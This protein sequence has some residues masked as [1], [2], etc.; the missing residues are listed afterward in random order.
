[1][2][3]SKIAQMV[4]IT[5]GA[6]LFLPA[7]S[8]T[9]SGLTPI[10]LG[11]P[12]DC[13]LGKDCFVQNYVDMDPGEDA[14]DFTCGPLAYNNHQGT[15]FRLRN[16][17]ALKRPYSALA[18]APGKVVQ[19]INNRP[20]HGFEEGAYNALDCGNAV[21]INHGGG[22]LSQYCHLAEGSV[23]VQNGD[24]VEKGQPIGFIGS[25]GGTSFPHLHYA[26]R[27]YNAT[28]DPFIGVSPTGCEAEEAGMLWDES[29]D[30]FYAESAVLGF[31]AT[32]NFP[33]L[34]AMENGNLS[35][36]PNEPYAPF[37][38]WAHLMG[39]KEGD[40]L[41]FLAFA[42]EGKILASERFEITEDKTIF[43]A[44]IGVEPSDGE[45]ESWPAGTYEG[46][47]AF[48]RGGQEIGKRSTTF[49]LPATLIQPA[50]ERLDD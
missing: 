1:M 36:K 7:A 17:A 29:V 8:P 15:D 43:S 49:T 30:I 25:S 27:A 3:F 39:V 31:G 21:M 6:I 22:W 23:R 20:D 34:E 37:Y 50:S 33:N 45:F 42:P 10:K 11:L 47:F 32:R 40:T 18:T 46:R 26:I 35:E 44:N 28:I 41:R 19:V 9:P 2:V 48:Y 16:R 4:V 5:F 24:Q 38:V 13:T 14:K 12:I